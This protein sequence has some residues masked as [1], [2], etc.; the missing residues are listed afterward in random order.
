M[1]SNEIEK[2]IGELESRKTELSKERRAANARFERAKQSLIAGK[3]ESKALE[4]NDLQQTM[5]VYDSTFKTIDE[6]LAALRAD[7]EIVLSSEKREA[8]L[9]ALVEAANEAARLA[10]E[11]EQNRREFNDACLNYSEKMSEN[12]RQIRARR[13]LLYQKFGEL[14]PNFQKTVYSYEPEIEKAMNDVFDEL[15]SRGANLEAIRSRLFSGSDRIFALDSDD[16][17]A[18]KLSELEFSEV[19]SLAMKILIRRS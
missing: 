17:T 11:Y 8:I 4:L 2:R 1:T 6:Q 19:I 16:S 18:L 7:L 13:N 12:V 14:V 15:R 5:A 10:D 3:T 9:N